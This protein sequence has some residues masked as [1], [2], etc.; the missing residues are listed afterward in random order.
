MQEMPSHL[1]DGLKRRHAEPWRHYHTWTHVEALLADCDEVQQLLHDPA[2]VRAAIYYHDAIY[3]PHTEDNEI[4]SAGLLLAEC[5]SVLT[6]NSLS[7]AHAMILAT[8][9]H[10]L[11]PAEDRMLEED[12]A[13]F[14]D[15]DLAILGADA[16]AFDRY[17]AQI[18]A[19]YAHVPGE[20]FRA[21][22]AAILKRFR[23]RKALF[24]TPHFA[25]KY[26]TRARANLAR[27][28]ERLA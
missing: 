10:E 2:A 9:A 19:E 26:E 22:R 28:L 11:P 25:A 3:D 7:H 15:M 4:R 23:A 20:A 13:Y 1:I 27:S 8:I 12:A 21:G 24:F 18:R 6:L 5:E 14:L 16:A 17:E